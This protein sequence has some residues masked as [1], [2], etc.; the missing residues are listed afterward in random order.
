MSLQSFGKVSPSLMVIICVKSGELLFSS[1][2]LIIHQDQPISPISPRRNLYC[3]SKI[4]STYPLTKF[5]FGLRRRLIPSLFLSRQNLLAGEPGIDLRYSKN[6]HISQS[7]R[8]NR[9]YRHLHT[10]P[11]IDNFA[12]LDSR[13]IDLLADFLCSHLSDYGCDRLYR[14]TGRR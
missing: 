4:L 6:I 10:Y 9:R 2:I 12:S 14:R 3:L 13:R 7:R 11:I 8:P 1:A 5:Q